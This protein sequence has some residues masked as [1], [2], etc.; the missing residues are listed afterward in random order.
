MAEVAVPANTITRARS[1]FYVWI[2][3]Y[4]SFLAFGGFTPT[5]FAPIAVGTLRDVTPVVHI[6]GFLFFAWTVMLLFQ[7][8]LVAEGRTTHHRA[9][10]LAG[11]SLA[12]AMVITGLI[13]NVHFNGRL[14]AEGEIER[15]Y[16]G[17]FNGWSSMILF[18]SFFAFA[19][20]NIKRADYHR[21]LMVIATCAILSAAVSR[22]YLPLFD[23]QPVPR[24]WV[25]L[26]IDL[27]I[28]A[29]L[30]NDWRTL[31]RP[32]VV[33]LVGGTVLVCRQLFQNQI[34]GTEAWGRAAEILLR[35]GG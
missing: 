1:L 16:Q 2:A 18:G 30:V 31:G 35:I 24:L 4:C 19:I 14:V 11:I 7:A 21:R 10:G 12:T 34:A 20:A 17:V 23:F 22:L 13:V 9:L 5:Y 28:I 26:T 32:H 8:W 6:H 15:G 27:I 25:N 3:V 33:T 29:V